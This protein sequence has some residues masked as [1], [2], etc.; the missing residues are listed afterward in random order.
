[1]RNETP[2]LAPGEQTSTVYIVLDDFGPQL[3]RVYRETDEATDEVRVIESIISGEYS[4]PVRVVAFNLAEGWA[5]D[6]TDEI[7]TRLL[8]AALVQGRVLGASAGE[9]V[10]RVTGQAVTV[11]V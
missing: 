8:D 1:M 5:R 6:V 9:F 11:A 2:P 10:E 4:R 7:A 3:G